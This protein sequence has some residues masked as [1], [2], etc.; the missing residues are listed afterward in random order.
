M[1]FP[2]D[3]QRDIAIICAGRRLLAMIS[4]ATEAASDQRTVEELVRL[5]L[6]QVLTPRC[7]RKSS[8]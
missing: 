2:A 3:S 5:M 8:R 6:T 7:G 1:S 4:P